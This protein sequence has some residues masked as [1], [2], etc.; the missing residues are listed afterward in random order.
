MKTNQLAPILKEFKGEKCI[1]RLTN[2]QL[3]SGIVGE[4]LNDSMTS[5]REVAIGNDRVKNFN[6]PLIEIDALCLA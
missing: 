2:G 5:I 6:I 4:I 1:L 3:I